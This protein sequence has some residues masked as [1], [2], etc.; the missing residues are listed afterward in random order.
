MRTR[1]VLGAVGLLVMTYGAWRVL[2]TAHLTRPKTLGVWLLAALVLHDAVLVPV[3]LTVGFVLGALVRPRAR[4]YIQGALVASGLVAAVAVVLIYRR[5]RAARITTLETQNYAAHLLV[6]V[7]AIAAVSAGAYA[8][9]VVRDARS[10]R[11]SAANVRPPADHD[12]ARP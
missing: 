9:R 3:T 6:I 10:Q 8:V 4:R 1:L 12:S 2:G 11:A 7:A 5:G